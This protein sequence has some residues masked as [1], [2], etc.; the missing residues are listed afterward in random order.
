MPVLVI[1]WVLQVGVMQ[2]MEI[3]LG[4]KEGSKRIMHICIILIGK[5]SIYKTGMF[6]EGILLVLLE[7]QGTALEIIYA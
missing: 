4:L 7:I 1:M 5:L 6:I 3:W 2:N